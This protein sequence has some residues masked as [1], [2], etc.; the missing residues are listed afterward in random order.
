MKK[1][2]NQELKQG[3]ILLALFGLLTLIIKTVGVLPDGPNG[4]EIG[5][6]SFNIWFNSMTGIHEVIYYITDWLQVIPFAVCAFFGCVGLKQWIERKN[7]AMVD[8]DIIILGIYYI[9][10]IAAYFFFQ[11]FPVNYRPVLIDGVLESSFPSSTTLLIV[12]VMPTLSFQAERRV[13]DEKK[14]RLVRLFAGLFTGVVVVLRLFCG[15]HWFTDVV[16]GVLLST[17]LYFL[18]LAA[19]KH[20]TSF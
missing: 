10:V 1:E 15:V 13:K 20:Y 4:S 3:L 7:I 8:A 12:S 19:V 17:G 6:G 11:F 5:L 16:A 2:I 14:R 18:Y 9:V